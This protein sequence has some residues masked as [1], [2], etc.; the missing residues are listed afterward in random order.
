MARYVRSDLVKSQPNGALAEETTLPWPRL[1]AADDLF[2]TTHQVLERVTD[3]FYALDREWRFTYINAAAER[4]FN[5]PR[6][7]MLGKDVWTEFAS[8]LETPVYAAYQ[9][10]MA[11]GA[12]IELEFSYP[13]FDA[14]YLVNAYPSEDGLSVFFRDVTERRQLIQDLRASEARYRTLVEHLPAVIY[15]QANDDRQTSTYF[16]PHFATLT[17]YSMAE[18]MDQPPGEHW[19]DFLH[20]DDRDRIAADEARS[21]ETGEPFRSEYRLRRRD[22]S[23]V[24]VRDECVPIYDGSGGVSAWQGIL[25]DITAQKEAEAAML[26]ALDA[27]QVASKAKSAFLATMSH[28]LRTPLQAVLGY[29][30][31]LLSSPDDALTAEQREDLS[32]IYQG[33]K[34]M[35]SLIAQMLDLS[36]IEAGAMQV[37]RA[38]VDLRAI[39]EEVRQDIA[40]QAQ[41][42]GL[43]L[44]IEA[45]VSL[46]HVLGDGLRLR[47]VLLNLAGNAVKFTDQGV[48]RIAAAS[49]ETG[50]TVSVHD[51]GIGIAPDALPHIFEE[52]RQ[53]DSKL[54][55]RHGG[56]GLGLAIAQ[57]LA[58]LM[59][60]RIDV[61]SEVGVG[62]AFTLRLEAAPPSAGDT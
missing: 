2:Q 31:F 29:A 57:K 53:V 30:E 44:L 4:I 15:E 3:G 52:F 59:G 61:E 16:S 21:V 36:R 6:E 20:P 62:S 51:T 32:Y 54:A 46:P 50:V 7:E 17:G 27:A 49:D 33:G 24:W 13:A 28:E 40:L 37:A 12:P 23:Y 18:I 55:R 47:Q 26:S 8:A 43:A 58:G 56:A 38:P 34:R 22:G 60:A 14:W 5:R 45:P 35:M 1:A 42:K 10:A 9:Q 19:H 25:I 39:L 41:A 48:V 11:E